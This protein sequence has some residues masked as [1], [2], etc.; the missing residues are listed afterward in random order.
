MPDET[1]FTLSPR[2]RRLW[3]WGVRPLVILILLYALAPVFL[4]DLWRGL[5]D[6]VAPLLARP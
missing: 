5:R 3:L 4:F 1:H 6:V 2:A